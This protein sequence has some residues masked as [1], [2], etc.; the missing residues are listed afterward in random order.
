MKPDVLIGLI[1]TV[2]GALCPDTK[3]D[4]AASASEWRQQVLRSR[5]RE[6]V[7]RKKIPNAKTPNFKQSSKTKKTGNGLGLGL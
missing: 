6:R 3:H 7:T 5:E 2:G 1:E 4:V